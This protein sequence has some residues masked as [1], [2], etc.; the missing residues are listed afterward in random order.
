MEIHGF[1]KN[2]RQTVNACGETL[3]LE[4]ILHTS[5]ITQSDPFTLNVGACRCP[6][7][8]WL[9][10]SFFNDPDPVCVLS[11]HEAP[12]AKVDPKILW[13]PD[14]LICGQ[15]LVPWVVASV[16]SWGLRPIA[17]TSPFFFSYTRWGGLADLGWRGELQNAKPCHTT[18]PRNGA[19]TYRNSMYPLVI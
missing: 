3:L 10:G 15:G 2:M 1:P 18:A 9:R 17:F 13:K 4:S 14:G 11:P 19:E 7:I 16:A 8:S 5:S 12:A 6:N